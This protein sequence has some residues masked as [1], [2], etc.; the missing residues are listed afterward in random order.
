MKTRHNSRIWGESSITFDMWSFQT[1]IIFSVG[2]RLVLDLFL[3][4]SQHA[5]SS[6]ELKMFVALFQEEHA[7]MVGLL[8]I[9]ACVILSITNLHPTIWKVT[10][11]N[12]YILIVTSFV[13]YIFRL[14]STIKM[15][16]KLFSLFDYVGNTI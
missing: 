10:G 7:P 12:V 1:D 11:R 4:I 13:R 2:R 3:L 6:H 16:Y 5:F 8:T 9:Y 14:I 15:F